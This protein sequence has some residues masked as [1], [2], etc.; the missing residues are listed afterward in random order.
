MLKKHFYPLPI[1]LAMF[2]CGGCS[3]EYRPS[4]LP[5]LFPV[6]LTFLLDGQPL[7]KAMVTLHTEDQTIAK[8]TIGGETDADGKAMI[9][10][11]GQFRGAPAGTFKVCVLKQTFPGQKQTLPDEPLTVENVMASVV[12]GDVRPLSVSEMPVPTYLVDPLFSTPEGTPMEIEVAPQ[13]KGVALT[14]DVHAPKK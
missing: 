5:P 1:I 4:D 14:F 7:D 9:V 12:G 6:T 11:H 3:N 10:T 13:K 8:W 2:V